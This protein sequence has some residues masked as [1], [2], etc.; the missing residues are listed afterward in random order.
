VELGAKKLVR[1]EFAQKMARVSLIA[2]DKLIAAAFSDTVLIFEDDVSSKEPL[3]LK[4][5]S[6]KA[7]GGDDESGELNV[8]AMSFNADR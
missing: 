4:Q 8:I 6:L 3:V 1:L 7:G 2:A 5:V